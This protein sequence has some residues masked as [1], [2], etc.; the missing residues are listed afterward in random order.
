MIKKC[1]GK[2]LNGEMGSY[3]KIYKMKQIPRRKFMTNRP[4]SSRLAIEFIINECQ[5]IP[6]KKRVNK[7]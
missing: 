4:V 7:G 2:Q 6:G 3:S 5:E 1:Y